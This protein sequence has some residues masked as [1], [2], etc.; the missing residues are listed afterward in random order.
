MIKIEKNKRTIL[1]NVLYAK[2]IHPAYLSK[3][4]SNHEKEVICLLIPNGKGQHY[5]AVKKRSGRG[6]MSKHHDDFY[7]LNCLQSFRT[8]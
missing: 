5:P 1:L 4:N 7:C 8:E 2:K 6:I 3:H